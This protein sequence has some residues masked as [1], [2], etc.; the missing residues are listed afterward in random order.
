MDRILVMKS[1]VATVEK[2]SFSAA[3][4]A[5]GHSRALVSRHVA[6][7]EQL[8]GTR[9]LNRTTRSVSLTETGQR[10]FLFCRRILDDI[11][12]EESSIAGLVERA[13]GPLNIVAPK[14]IGNLDV[15]DAVAAFAA[16]HPKIKVRFELGHHYRGTHEFV[17]EGFDVS[18]QTKPIV[19]SSIVVKRVATLAYVLCASPAYLRQHGEP[20][21][22]TDLA[23]HQALVHVNEPAWQLRNGTQNKRIKMQEITFSSNTFLVLRNATCSG[24]GIALM[25]LGSVSGLLA[26]GTLRLVL[27]RCRIPDRPLYVAHAPGSGKVERVRCFVNFISQWFKR[28]P[29]PARAALNKGHAGPFG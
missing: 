27:P 28:H 2:R 22:V 8:L 15:G 25:P 9:L 19:D 4:S 11:R 12:N 17:D 21:N 20:Q 24:L 14:W 6:D 3:A 29:M 23:R 13:E 18:F 5:L 26:A 1:F 7:L 16:T 10:Y